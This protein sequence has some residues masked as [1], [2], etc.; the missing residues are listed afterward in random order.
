LSLFERNYRRLEDIIGRPLTDLQS[1]IVYRLRAE[2]FMDLVV[3][4]LPQDRDTGAMVVSLAHYFT[5]HGD[6]C[7][8]PEMV[9]RAF[10]PREGHPGL[11]EALTFTQAIPPIYSRVYPEPGKVVPRLKREL[12]SFLGVWLRNLKAQG[13]RLVSERA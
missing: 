7:Q 10:P 11:L 2:N 4:V 6:L 13:H 1:G 8:D 3:E 5:Q 12:N 9:V